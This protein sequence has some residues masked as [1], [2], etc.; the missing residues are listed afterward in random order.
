MTADR[1]KASSGRTIHAELR[2]FSAAHLENVRNRADRLNVIDDRGLR[3]E[4]NVNR[5]RWLNPWHAALAFKTLDQCRF[6]AA[7]VRTGTTVHNDFQV[8]S[9]TL[10]VGAD[11]SRASGLVDRRLHAIGAE[12]EFAAHVNKRLV[13]TDAICLDTDT[14]D[15]RVWVAFEQHT[16]FER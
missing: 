5:Q 7:D 3:I 15:Q 13:R 4:T 8:K 2:V 16:V 6:F 1:S 11:E 14:F 12:R 10:N 9:R